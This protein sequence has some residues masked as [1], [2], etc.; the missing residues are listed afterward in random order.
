MLQMSPSYERLLIQIYS[1]RYCSIGF[2]IPYSVHASQKIANQMQKRRQ[3]NRI[4]WRIY[5][6]F[7][8]NMY[9]LVRKWEDRQM[10]TL[11]GKKQMCTTPN[12]DTKFIK[13][14]S[15]CLGIGLPRRFCVNST[16]ADLILTRTEFE[17]LPRM[18]SSEFVMSHVQFRC[19]TQTVSA[20]IQFQLA[21]ECAYHLSR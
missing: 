16:S 3:Q 11:N 14:I 13:N 17:I 10:G 20:L 6:I 5:F 19:N 8:S 1:I 12:P 4:D 2:H 18:N 9:I 7:N 15:K 21:F